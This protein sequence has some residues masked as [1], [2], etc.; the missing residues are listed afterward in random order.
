MRVLKCNALSK[1]YLEWLLKL[2]KNSLKI[3]YI[4]FSKR[5]S[6]QHV[7]IS[8]K[9]IDS[10]RKHTL[11]RQNLYFSTTSVDK[12]YFILFLGRQLPKVGNHCFTGHRVGIRK[13][14]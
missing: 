12:L 6:K 9:S 11:V 3:Q 14:S 10:Q 2:T 1:Y 4:D 13:T 7:T 8:L 5:T